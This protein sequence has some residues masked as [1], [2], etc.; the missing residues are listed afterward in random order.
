MHN[1]REKQRNAK[2]IVDMQSSTTLVYNPS[3]PN[4][5]PKKYT[6]DYSYWSHDGFTQDGDTS[7]AQAD[8][9][10]ANCH[11]YA[12]QNRVYDDLGKFL[13]NNA[14]Q[15][16][17]ASLFAYG[18]TGSG[19]SYTVIGY[20]AN[21]G[22]VPRFCENL[23][24]VVDSRKSDQVT[25]EVK[26]SMLEIYNEVVRDL[27]NPV[28]LASKKVGL[29]VREH[30]NRGFFA[31]GLKSFLVTGQQ[32]IE[33]KIAEGTTNRS[34][35]STN[36]NETSSRAHT[37]V[38]ISITQKSRNSQNLESAKSS[39]VHLV[40]LAGSERLSGTK[41]KGERLKEGVSINQSLACLGN[42]IHS[43]AEK[44]SG[45]NVRVPFRESVLTRLLMNALG[46][47]SKTVM[48]ATISPADVNY[49]ETL[50][51]LRY[52]DRAKQIKVHAKVNQDR[53]DQLIRQL[54]DENDKL[55]QLMTSNETLPG[56]VDGRN[57]AD[58][59]ELRKK[60]ED[61]M[62]AAMSENERQLK[63]MRQTYEERLQSQDK[64]ETVDLKNQQVEQDKLSHPHLS[65][66]N[67]DEQLSG[68][69]NYIIRV[70]A[71]VVGKAEDSQII[72]YGPSI[73]DRHAV[74][75]R[76]D[77]GLI[78]LEKVEDNCRVLLNG[79][80]VTTKVSLS[81]HDR[82]LFGSTQLF[83]FKH[84]DQDKKS[85]MTFSEVTFELA[86]EEIAS[87]A[88][89]DVSNEDQTIEM[90]L[91]NKDLLE[92]LPGIEEAN[93]ISEELEKSMRFDIML[94]SA[95][96]LGKSLDRTE[97]YVRVTNIETGQTFEWPKEKFINRL[98]VMK[99]MYQN[100][101]NN[102]DWD[103]APERDPFLEEP[104]AE[105]L[106]GSCH[107]Y[108]QPL[109]FMVEIK[110][111]LE[112]MD[113][114]GVE[115]GVLNVEMVPCNGQG[116]EYDETDD[117]YVDSPSELIGKEV[118]F[119]VKVTAARGLP[120]RFTDVYAKYR[121][122]LDKDDTRT[123]TISDTSNPDFNHRKVF[124]FRPATQQLIDYLK[125]S[126]VVIQIWGKQM[127][128]G[129]ESKISGRVTKNKFQEDLMNE[130]NN[131]MDGFK[132]NGR[133][134]EMNKQSIIVELLLMKKQ[135]ARQQQRI[136]NIRKLIEVSEQYNKMAVPVQLVKDLLSTT[137]PEVAEDIISQVPGDNY[138]N[139]KSS[140]CIIL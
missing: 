15:G 113:F 118:H 36:M 68:K 52:A 49:D 24:Q 56:Q 135:Q 1:S 76:K 81:H 117:V 105:S 128:R 45:K 69:I 112:L 89:Y 93:A 124:S 30:P 17:N 134:V 16:Y 60:W 11:K 7:Y 73:Q 78:I 100:Y 64:V 34:I 35:A 140:S 59:D 3:S 55:K 102:E 82:L 83:V 97:V 121:M 126:S 108:L 74:I 132:M 120:A 61:E 18:Q 6:F 53:T 58:I 54:R 116:Q 4:E 130:A 26:L 43:L 40:D 92:T 14:L 9:A 57:T 27:L 125:D 77:N 123:E 33:V 110:E 46:G 72:L 20:G 25:F 114:R 71:N 32:D 47:N 21:Q 2:C 103:L 109:A 13:L 50:S 10:H 66:L 86:Q 12:D 39:N 41:A 31:E 90:A 115:V 80:P 65:N 42:C 98:F 75:Y 96:F 131:L 94:V 62:H 19:K 91:L 70:G 23:F 79:D 127:S 136:E 88:G 5:E 129:G 139:P 111:Q 84:P 138:S 101:E 95:Q 22:I 63:E 8:S 67:F 87:K 37:L 85:R 122:F 44:S 107:L 48:M 51:T 119:V 38:S 28:S 137:T 133:H 29:K 99:E 104:D 106:I